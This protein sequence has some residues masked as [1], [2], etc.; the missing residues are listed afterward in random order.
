MAAAQ[1][2]ARGDEI[3]LARTQCSSWPSRDPLPPAKMEG[4]DDVH[5]HKFSISMGGKT[6]FKDC[7]L[8][9]AHGRRYGLIGPNGCGKSTL[10]TAIGKQTNEEI[11][12]G[13]PPQMDIL[14]VEQEVAASK[15][16]SAVEM[17]VLADE[18]RT[19]LLKEEKELTKQL[20]EGGVKYVQ[21]EKLKGESF[22]VGAKVTFEGRAVTI[23]EGKDDEGDYTIQDAFDEDGAIAGRLT[24]VHEE[25]TDIGADSAEARASAILTGL[26]ARAHHSAQFGRK[27]AQFGRNSAQFGAIL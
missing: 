26:Q 7:P 17:V 5:V 9:L 1:P 18:R 3:S 24:E 11:M 16:I 14:L 13:I 2:E 23:L 22:E 19:A 12:A 10:M 4:S 25:L 21:Q 27:S 20:E 8:S 6:L 15:T